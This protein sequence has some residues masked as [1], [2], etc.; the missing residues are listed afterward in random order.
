MGLDIVHDLLCAGA[1]PPVMDCLPAD[2][3]HFPAAG[4]LK[5]CGAKRPRKDR[6]RRF[7]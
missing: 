3:V 5:L 2:A 1:D 6:G 7:M 4:E